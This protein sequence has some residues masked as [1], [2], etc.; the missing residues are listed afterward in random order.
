MRRQRGTQQRSEKEETVRKTFVSM[1]V[2]ARPVMAPAAFAQTAVAPK[3]R[4]SS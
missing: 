3:A 4:D 2:A 1:F